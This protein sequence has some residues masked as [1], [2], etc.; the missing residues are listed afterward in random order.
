M[1]LVLL[2]LRTGCPAC[3]AAQ[4]RRDGGNPETEAEAGPETQA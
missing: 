2:I 3:N 1:D 4:L